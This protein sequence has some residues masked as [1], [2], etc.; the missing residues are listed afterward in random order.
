M[1][2]K[3]SSQLTNNVVL[4]GARKRSAKN[5]TRRSREKLQCILGNLEDCACATLCLCTGLNTCPGNKGDDHS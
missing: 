1:G 3:A 5:L 4:V 2:E